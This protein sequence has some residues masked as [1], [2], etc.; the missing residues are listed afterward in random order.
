GALQAVSNILGTAV[1]P[2][3]EVLLPAPFWFQFT[4]L[5][6]RTGA[7]EKIIQTYPGNN[8]R[9]TPKLLASAIT[10]A[11]RVLI[12]TAPNNPSGAIYNQAELA[13]LA[14]VIHAHPGLLAVS[15]A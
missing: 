15:D 12:L 3:D 1:G 8:Y 10:P 4:H 7:R 6:R 11:S 13:A 5:V 2:G 14:Q 9:L